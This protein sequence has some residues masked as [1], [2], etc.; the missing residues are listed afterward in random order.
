MII[1]DDAATLELEPVESIAGDEAASDVH[2]AAEVSTPLF[3]GR[4]PSV[5]IAKR[6]WDA[7]L[8]TLRALET[9]R[10]GE[11]QLESMSPADLAIRVHVYD[12]RGHIKITGHVGSD[13]IWRDGVDVSRLP[14]RIELDPTKLAA[15]IAG[16]EQVAARIR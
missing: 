13:V 3:S 6:A 5:W 10:M 15:M 1:R 14:F 8:T 16:L 2:C 4:N 9:E 12:R 7:F 11:A